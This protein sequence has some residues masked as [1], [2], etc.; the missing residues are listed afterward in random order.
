MDSVRKKSLVIDFKDIKYQV[1]YFYNA[2][3][4]GVVCLS[5]WALGQWLLPLYLAQSITGLA[6][7]LA[8]LALAGSLACIASFG[9]KFYIQKVLVGKMK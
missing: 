1:C 3:F 2:V 9:N 6:Y 8:H 7:F 5:F 4:V